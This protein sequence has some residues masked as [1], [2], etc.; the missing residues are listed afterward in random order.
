MNDTTAPPPTPPA[1]AYPIAFDVEPQL[2]GRN[3]L[4]VAFR[5]I[6]AIPHLI[7]VGGPGIALGGGG[8]WFQRGH[9][10][11]RIFS[12]VPGNG[13]LGA[14]AFIIA[15]IAWFAIVF[16]GQHPRG[17]WDFSRMYMRWRT[18]AGVYIALLRDEYPP[19][20]EAEY[21]VT[22]EVAYPEIRR[23][24]WSVGLRFI[25]AIPHVFVLFFLGIAWWFT[26]V[27]AWFAILFSGSYPAG[28]YRFGVGVM[29]WSVRVESYVLLMRDEYPPFSMEP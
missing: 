26:T 21:P 22:Y 13:V 5:I 10:V 9:P 18:K 15:V 8:Y 29:R 12:S 4:T 24:R 11:E 17:L 7:I 16:S 1:A 19:F 20:G 2:T 14:V 6:L 23:D 25:Y 27:I 3:R 28:L